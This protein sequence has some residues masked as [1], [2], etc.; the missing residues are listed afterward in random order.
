MNID[1]DFYELPNGVE[2]ARVFLD[3]LD[4]KLFLFCW[5]EGNSNKWLC[6]EIG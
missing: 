2:P 3:S 4:I 5:K 1:V 6:K